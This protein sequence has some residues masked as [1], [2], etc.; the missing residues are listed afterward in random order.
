MQA[1]V[2]GTIICDAVCVCGA[3]W[4]NTTG[5]KISVLMLREHVVVHGLTLAAHCPN[6]KPGMWAMLKLGWPHLD[7][8]PAVVVDDIT[9]VEKINDEKSKFL[10]RITP[11]KNNVTV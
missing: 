3:L 9:V 8:K 4:I 10:F 7:I 6:C 1:P 5:V 11:Q 2:P